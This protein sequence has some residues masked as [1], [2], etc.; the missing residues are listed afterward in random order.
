MMQVYPFVRWVAPSLL[1]SHALQDT[2]LVRFEQPALLAFDTP[3]FMKELMGRLTPDGMAGLVAQPE[4]VTPNQEN[5]G[6]PP[7][8]WVDETTWLWESPLSLYPPSIRRYYVVAASF[9][10]MAPGLPDQA[11]SPAQKEEVGFLLRRLTPA[12]EQA[13]LTS[14][15]WATAPNPATLVDGEQLLPAG[16]VLAPSNTGPRRQIWCTAVPAFR[17]PTYEA[18]AIP[19]S[20]LGSNPVMSDLLSRVG[21]MSWLPNVSDAV[22]AASFSTMLLL[23]LVT[24]LNRYI[25]GWVANNPFQQPWAQNLLDVWANRA[26]LITGQSDI[27]AYSLSTV[28]QPDDLPKLIDWVARQ[29]QAQENFYLPDPYHWLPQSMGAR[30]DASPQWIPPWPAVAGV[31]RP[32]WRRPAPTGW[33]SVVGAPS[34]PFGLP[35]VTIASEP[36]Q[37]DLQQMK[38]VIEAALNS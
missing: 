14:G 20:T 31:V 2:D 35:S 17:Q 1:W 18:A 36:T 38:V 21:A 32:V 13:W 33:Q 15:S 37:E 11:V 29:P 19:G 22:Q 34:R 28:L 4:P 24:F 7:R 9:V 30:F 16:P 26:P 10:A 6:T 5:P 23:S 8:G 27:P 3:S 25:P 12:G